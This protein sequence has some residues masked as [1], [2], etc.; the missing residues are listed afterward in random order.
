MVFEGIGRRFSTNDEFFIMSKLHQKIST[1]LYV[2]YWK[3]SLVGLFAMLAA[4][5]FG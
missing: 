5:A 3:M 1:R 4:P 2:A